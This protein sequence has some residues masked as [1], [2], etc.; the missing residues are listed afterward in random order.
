[1]PPA[2]RIAAV[3]A[4]QTASG[5][6]GGPSPA[7]GEPPAVPCE[8]PEALPCEPPL[9]EPALMSGSMSRDMGVW[10]GSGVNQDMARGVGVVRG[11]GACD[12]GIAV[13]SSGSGVGSGPDP[14]TVTWPL[15]AVTDIGSPMVFA[16]P[17]YVCEAIRLRRLVPAPL[18]EKVTV[19]SRPEPLGP[20]GPPIVAQ[21]KR[22]VSAGTPGAG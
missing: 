7:R 17:V 21:P 18:G 3:I 6:W 22:R 8:P 10:P 5:F 2:A 14:T 13:G 9:A 20:E 11:G 12:V 16:G 15:D 19:A 4:G 1:M